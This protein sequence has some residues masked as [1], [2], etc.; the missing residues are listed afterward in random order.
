MLIIMNSLFFSLSLY[1]I[2][3]FII[4]SIKMFTNLLL[5]IKISY[6]YWFLT[7]RTF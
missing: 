3:N 2:I 1:F 4:N 6:V 7:T 5:C